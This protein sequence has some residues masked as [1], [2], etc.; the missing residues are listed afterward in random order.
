MPQVRTS[1]GV[2]SSM[3]LAA[4]YSY[5][6]LALSA[7]L[8]PLGVRDQLERFLS[9]VSKHYNL[10]LPMSTGLIVLSTFSFLDFA[11]DGCY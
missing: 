7:H 11:Y 4:R 6:Q 8:G 3:R 10:W 5:R 2:T 9:P 1:S